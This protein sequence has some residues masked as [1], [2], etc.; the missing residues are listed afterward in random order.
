MHGGL[1]SLLAA[2]GSRSLRL[3]ARDFLGFGVALHDG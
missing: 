2:N 3:L 1:T